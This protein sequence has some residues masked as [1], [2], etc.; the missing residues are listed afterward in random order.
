MH[1]ETILAVISGIKLL[2]KIDFS[3]SED[4]MEEYKQGYMDAIDAVY[5]QFEER[6]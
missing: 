4:G 1:K 2:A 3:Q 5:K 6:M